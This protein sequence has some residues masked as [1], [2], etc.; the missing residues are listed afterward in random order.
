MSWDAVGFEKFRRPVTMS[1]HMR[2]KEIRCRLNAKS[3][4]QEKEYY[5]TIQMC[6]I[7]KHFNAINT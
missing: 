3:I 4:G 6:I 1:Y 2:R 5:S 7:T